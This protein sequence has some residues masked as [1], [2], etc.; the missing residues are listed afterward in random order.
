VSS[1]RASGILLHPT[2]F[3]GPYSIGDLGPQAYRFVDFLHQT[4][5]TLWQILPLTPTG[6]GASPYAAF[7][8]FACNPLLLSPE[9]LLASGLLTAEDLQDVPDFP[10]DTVDYDAAIIWKMALLRRSYVH[11][12][13]SA[14]ARRAFASFAREN[15]GWLDDYALFMAIKEGH[16]GSSWPDWEE[17]IALRRPES[18]ARWHESADDESRFQK[19]IQHLF[20]TQWFALKRYAN[21]RGVQIV[22]DIPIFVAHDSAD[23][24]AHP[25][26]FSLDDTGRPTVVAGVPPDYFSATGQYWGNPHYRW[27]VM[28]T[29]SYAWWVERFRAAFRL[30]DRVRLD[31]FRGFAAAWAVPANAKQSATNGRW[32]TGPGLPFFA[33]VREALG[34][35]PIIAEDLGLIT[36]DVI[37]LR[38]ALE[39][40]G[41]RVLQFAFSAPPDAISPHL[42]H[43]FE[44]NSVVYTGT[45][46]ND[47]TIGWYR[48]ASEQVRASVKHYLD[49]QER[50]GPEDVDRLGQLVTRKLVRAAFGSVANSA[51]VPMQDL[52]ELGSAARMNMPGRADGN[53]QW[54]YEDGALTDELRDYLRDITILF[55]R[56]VPPR[57]RS[58]HAPRKARAEVRKSSMV[59]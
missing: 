41:M 3:P 53:W 38:E 28:A 42:P 35:R 46:D 57:K 37:E 45:H 26:L 9:L 27:E 48:S 4:G 25:E 22:G 33:A 30:Y 1:E 19:Y 10:T 5:Q 2:S 31:H 34:E 54:R 50:G 43:N 18:L 56:H 23:V 12:N 52:L 58:V 20:F 24:W 16:A 36:P 47:T 59:E 39:F 49:I 55:A 13:R 6:H 7:S 11:F 32:V 21:T 40:P 14:R 15:A 29:D 44:R 51:I 8:A 17:G